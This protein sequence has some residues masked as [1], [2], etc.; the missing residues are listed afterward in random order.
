MPLTPT[1]AFTKIAALNKPIRLV[2]GGTSSSKTYSILM[3]LIYY[4]LKRELT[5][6]VVAESIPVLKRGA[7]R[8]FIHILKE[9]GLYEEKNH[10]QTDRLYKL[11]NST[12]EF[13]SAEDSSK[14]RGSRRNILFLNEANNVT[15]E[16]FNELSIRTKEFCICDWNPTAVFWANTE[17]I[18]QDNV[19]FITLTYKDNEFLEQKIV[20]EIE[21]WE[22]K[23]LTSKYW[24]NK[25]RVMG[26]G[27]LGI[28]TGAIYTDWSEI[29]FLPDQA[30]L[31]GTGLDFGYS[32]DECAAIAVYRYDGEIIVDE[33]VYQ[34]GLLNSQLASLLKHSNSKH[35]VIYGDSAEPKSIAELK[36]YGLNVQPVVKGKDSINYGI[37]LIQSTP[38]KVTS[39]S[40]NLIKELQNYTWAKDREGNSLSNPIDNWNHALDALR[41]LF[42]M[43]FSKKA[44][45]FSLKW[46]R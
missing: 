32:N 10:N 34:K 6:S 15:F 19:D 29:D 18:G 4:S 24:A 1:T 8:D 9:L 46:R 13:F 35:G 30:E 40:K 23:G 31:I 37:Q 39:R 42:L 41:Y 2:C 21:S 27:Q 3:Y 12:F 45:T 44:T 7:Y 14:L 25:W 38:F 22:V 43:K 5:I 28:Q 33:V 16:A 20:K 36:Q 17:L 26:L 11:N